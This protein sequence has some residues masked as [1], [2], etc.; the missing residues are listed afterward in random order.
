MNTVRTL[1][2]FK[3]ELMNYA[4]F[5][6]MRAYVSSWVIGRPPIVSPTH[7]SSSESSEQIIAQG[8]EASRN[9]WIKGLIFFQRLPTNFAELSRFEARKSDG[10]FFG[11]K[12]LSRWFGKVEV[13]NDSGG[14]LLSFTGRWFIEIDR[15]RFQEKKDVRVLMGWKR[16]ML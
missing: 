3:K 9:H 2:A 15:I 16:E 5:R 13:M 6:V 12:V 14:F 7:S 1:E 4:Y 10:F 8:P 11:S